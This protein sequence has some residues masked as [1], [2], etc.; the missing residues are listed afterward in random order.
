[1]SM[2]DTPRC[3]ES[4]GIRA[5]GCTRSGHF[6]DVAIVITVLLIAKS[7]LLQWDAAWK[8]AGPMSLLL[9]FAVASWRLKARGAS[10]SDLGLS[11]PGSWW[12]LIFWTVLA[13]VV[14]VMAG[15]IIEGLFASV[16]EQLPVD[17]EVANRYSNRFAELPGNLSMFVLWLLM[18]WIIGGFVEEL[19]FRGYLLNKCEMA[20]RGVP[21]AVVIAVLIQSILFGQQHF[22]YQGLGGAL[23]TGTLAAIS[24]FFYLLGKRNLW[25]LI[26]SHGLANTLGLSALYLGL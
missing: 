25:A 24:A 12:F 17:T 6:S 2:I 1:M 11:W 14:T 5:R 16:A 7:T 19:I 10:W 20:M 18:G 22:Y 8:Y 9:T 21:G 3:S 4:M 13:L 23:A 26:L 15:G